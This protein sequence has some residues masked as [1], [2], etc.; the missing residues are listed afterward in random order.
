[1]THLYNQFDQ[2]LSFINLDAEVLAA[3][4]ERLAVA[5]SSAE[6]HPEGRRS[7]ASGSIAAHTHIQPHG[8]KVSDGDGGIILDRVK[9]PS[10]GPDGAYETPHEITS[11]LVAFVGAEIRQ[12]Y[13]KARVYKSKRGLKIHFGAPVNGIDVTIDLI[14]TLARREGRGLWIPNLHKEGRK[15]WEACDPIGHAELLNSA[16]D[17]LRRM[18]RKAIR[19]LKAWNAQMTVPGFSSHNLSVWAYEFIEPGMG[20]VP[21]IHTV[22]SKAAQR[23]DSGKP[24][25]DPLEV[26]PDIQPLVT[27]ETAERRLRLAAAK[28]QTAQ[29]APDDVDAV[30]EALAYLFPK[31]M[32]EI[33]SSFYTS[34]R[35]RTTGQL[36][37]AGASLVL[38]KNRS[39]RTQ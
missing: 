13:R 1:M 11:K 33:D 19:L 24:T 9:H 7:Y 3:T 14:V 17:A 29:D 38:P 6:K 15:A 30:R 36:G 26:S 35:L 4:R 37:L 34:G 8:D 5:R 39:W 31:T 10:L 22:M 21:A 28:L 23:M 32:S 2:L 16:P 12:N 20:L 18:R 27:Y 25:P